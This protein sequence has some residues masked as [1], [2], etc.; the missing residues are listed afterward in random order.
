MISRTLRTRIPNSSRP[1]SKVRYLPARASVST[2]GDSVFSVA[3]GGMVAPDRRSNLDRAGLCVRMHAR[4]RHLLARSERQP[5]QQRR[6]VPIETQRR[7]FG[8]PRAAGLEISAEN[9][10]RDAQPERPEVLFEVGLDAADD[11]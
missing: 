4:V 8:R 9:D 10:G 2:A 5:D 6:A 3:T 7:P 11:H 1:R